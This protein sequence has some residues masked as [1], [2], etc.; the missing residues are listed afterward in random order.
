MHVCIYI[1]IY[2]HTYTDIHTY[3]HVY[4]HPGGATCLTFLHY[5]AT[6]YQRCLQCLCSYYFSIR[7]SGCLPGG[8]P[9][10]PFCIR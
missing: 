10:R 9:L 5:L 8:P 4:I 1:Y 3:I 6:C 7:A 2:T